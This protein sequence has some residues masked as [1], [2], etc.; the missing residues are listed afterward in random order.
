MATSTTTYTPR[1]CARDI[2][3]VLATHDNNVVRATP[4]IIPHIQT[5]MRRPDLLEMGTP[6]DSAHTKDSIWLY[7][8]PEFFILISHPEKDVMV[9]P[10]N[11]G[12]WEAIGLYRGALQYS[13]YQRQDDA[14]RA[15]FADLKQSESRTLHPGDATLLPGPPNDIHGFTGLTA[16]TY[17][18]AVSTGL[19]S[20]VR[21][22]FNPEA[23]TYTPRSEN[24]WRATRSR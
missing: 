18:V 1:Q 12:T 23:K 5:L 7:Y 21:N 16:D 2:L 10:H 17:I 6:R 15:G 24:T 8:D 19:Y 4:E 13:R 20:P 22:Y 3:A 11:H 14:S 9:P